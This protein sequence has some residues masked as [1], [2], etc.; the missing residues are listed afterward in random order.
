MK[1]INSFITIGGDSRQ[2][3]MAEHLNMLGYSISA[4][5]LP[6]SK[7]KCV[8]DL[9]AEI[10]NKDAVILPLPVTK[11]GK[12]I[13]SIVPVKES[14]D[15]IISLIKPEQAV[16]AGMISKGLENKIKSRNIKVYDYFKREDVTVMN[17]VPTV[18]GILKA[19]IDNIDYTIFSSRCAIFGYG[20]VSKITADSLSSLGAKITVCA[21]KYG[22]LASAEIKGYDS[23]LINDFYKSANDFNII[24]NTVPS[25]VIDKKILRNLRKDCLI[26]DVSSAPFGVDFTSAYDL[27]I[28]SLQCS[29]LPGKVAPKTAGKII[30]DGIMNIIKEEYNG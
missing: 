28:K 6:E 8:E 29:S 17:T 23:C 5:G 4:Y 19:I 18:Q 9:R 22:D 12:Y 15:E 1:P 2:I 7:I 20:R 26:I 13:Q 24:I 3:Y 27:G 25:L 14:V 30:A 11:D 10:E 16:F 21:R